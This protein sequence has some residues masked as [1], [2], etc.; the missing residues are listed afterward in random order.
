MLARSSAARHGVSRKSKLK[1]LWRLIGAD[2]AGQPFR[3]RDP[4]LG[5]EHLRVRI[6]VGDAAP[7]AIHLVH[8]VAVPERVVLPP[9]PRPRGARTAS[10]DRADRRACAARWRRRSGSRRRRGRTR[11]AAPIRTRRGR[12]VPP[13][14]VRLPGS[15][16]C[17]YHSPACRRA[18]GSA[19]RLTR[20]R[21]SPSRSAAASRRPPGSEQEALPLVRPRSRRKRGLK[22]WVLARHVVRD[23]VEQHAQAQ[24]SRLGDERL[25]LGQGPEQRVDRTVVG[26]VVAGVGHRRRIPRVQP[27]RVDA[28]VPDVRQAAADSLDVADAVAV[29]VGEAAWVDLVRD[30]IAP[31]GGGVGAGGGHARSTY[32]TAC[33]S[34]RPDSSSMMSGAARRPALRRSRWSSRPA[35]LRRDQDP[36]RHDKRAEGV[37]D[38]GRHEHEGSLAH[39]CLVL[40]TDE[41]VATL[42]HQEPFAML[43]MECGAGPPRPPVSPRSARMR[44]PSRAPADRH[45]WHCPC[46]S[47]RRARAI[48]RMLTAKIA[49]PL[50]TNQKLIGLSSGSGMS[51]FMPSSPATTEPGRSRTV[52]SARLS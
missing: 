12:P 41:P 25:G 47:Q 9:P 45:S 30:G 38:T 35:Q 11:S 26:D 14:Q 29:P 15:K 36:R 6:R 8:G 24:R 22:P 51:M 10:R 18:R 46:H 5:H 4:G 40:A 42:E 31:P 43:A 32:A 7:L 13:V 1:A 52:A 44:R 48:T 23:D 28:E 27:D 50:T 21:R 20:R 2:V 17:R 3:S 37:P 39:V 49:T 34:Y 16:R 19:S 33:V